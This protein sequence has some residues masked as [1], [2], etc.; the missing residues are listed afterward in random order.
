MWLLAYC[1]WTPSL[2]S[3]CASTM[4]DPL[5]PDYTPF[6]YPVTLSITDLGLIEAQFVPIHPPC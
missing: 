6:L 1:K 4:L 2:T 3:V 5:D